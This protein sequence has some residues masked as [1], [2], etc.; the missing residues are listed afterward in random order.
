[1][2]PYLLAA[3][4]A[5]IATCAITPAVRLCAVRKGYL[6]H[7]DKSRKFHGESKPLGGGVAVYLAILLAV[8]VTYLTFSSRLGASTGDARFLL[9]L[10]LASTIIL[11]TGV[12]DDVA[13]LGGLQK[14]AG[15]FL[16]VSVFIILEPPL[17]HI[18][19]FGFYTKLSFMAVPFVAFWLL[20]AINSVN[21]LDGADGIAT[22]VGIIVTGTSVV[23]AF[24]VG[25]TAEAIVAMA[26]LGALVGFLL[27]N[28]PPSSIF[29]GDAGS[30]L[31]GLLVGVLAIRCH[32]KEAATVALVGPIALM[33]IP[34]IDSTAAIVRRLLTGKNIFDG[35]H[36][37]L[38]HV[39]QRRGLNPKL[40]VFAVAVLC[41]IPAVGTIATA[42]SNNPTYALTSSVIVFTV[43]VTFSFFRNE[44][45]LVVNRLLRFSH[46][47]VP[48]KHA[49]GR[50]TSHCLGLRQSRDAEDIWDTLVS[51]S[52]VQDISRI[53]L[54]LTGDWLIDGNDVICERLQKGGDRHS[55]NWTTRYPLIV[56]DRQLGTFS[57][58]GR[59]RS[60]NVDKTPLAIHQ[61]L[62][63]IRPSLERI[64]EERRKR[65]NVEQT[66]LFINRS[67]WPDCEATGQLLTD[68]CERVATELNVTVIAG[69]PNENPDLA[70]YVVGGV[71]KRN[72]VTIRRVRHSKLPKRSIPLRAVNL[73]S[74]VV[75]ATWEAFCTPK[76]DVVVV[77]TDP[78]LLPLLGA[79]LKRWSGCRLIVYV[80]D[81]Y[82]DVAVAIGK[83]R[84]GFLTRTIRKLL[85]QAYQ[86]ADKIIVLGHDM[87]DR[88][89]SHG[90]DARKI[91][92]I[93][94]WVD[95][96]A[97]FPVKDENAFRQQNGL[98][99]KFVVMHSGNMGL[100]QGLEQIIEA[101]DRL[102][103]RK[104]IVFAL[105]G[106]GA[107]KPYLEHEVRRRGLKN[108]LIKPYQPR[109]D[110]A[111]SL[112]A[113][114]LHIVSMHSDICGVLVPSKIYGIMASGTPILAIVPPDTD[115]AEI[116]ENA[117]IGTVI[118]P[119]DIAAITDHIEWATDG[120]V[121]LEAQGCRARK[122]AETQHDTR[123]GPQQILKLIQSSLT[124]T[125]TESPQR[126]S[127]DDHTDKDEVAGG[128]SAFADQ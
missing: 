80:Q 8:S 5:F 107:K 49:D 84:E 103:H 21:L 60:E 98:D 40:T 114:D 24:S 105:V 13:N 3:A 29:L 32:V 43:L 14:L 77:E 51:F 15:Q 34:I 41:L 47:I 17:D 88:L 110:L 42:R 66:A 4:F 52:V 64:A 95:T 115:V 11:I 97:V 31:I 93:P 120:N 72:G 19:A 76:Q 23:I 59:L 35:D 101:A 58:T 69:K 87:K 9:G 73:V 71:E 96:E 123:Y 104:D 70:K 99:D 82:P 118:Q 20:G 7:P 126:P 91:A 117:E 116:V 85:L 121:D 67:Y 108:V 2:F 12:L 36:A 79:E 28:F 6:D 33:S 16:A 78:F 38:H 37:H 102:R 86:R 111:V 100:T 90:V 119:G 74:F 55:A 46:A 10:L 56:D 122:L 26:T 83:V 94:N 45:N 75:M 57:L 18:T 68:L 127:T 48:P 125:R 92:I 112:S 1:M 124:G 109:S 54:H 25:H 81:I 61:L 89:V 22:T 113:A 27:F 50:E 44:C 65:E 106:G 53:R 63:D 30:M 128:H 62:L 39:L